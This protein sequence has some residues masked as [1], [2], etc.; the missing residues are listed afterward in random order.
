VGGSEGFAMRGGI[1]NFTI[2]G[3]NIHFEIRLAAE[4]AGLKISSRLLSLARVVTEQR[5]GLRG[6]HEPSCGHA[7]NIT[8]T[9]VTMELQLIRWTHG[10]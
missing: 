8:H 7:S 4:R 6:P 3:G 2:E 10:A 1:I 9:I 5:R